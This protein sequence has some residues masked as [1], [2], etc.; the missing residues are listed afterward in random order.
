M[1]KENESVEKLEAKKYFSQ[2]FLIDSFAKK[3]VVKAMKQIADI[4][5]CTL[6]EVGPGQGDV[7][8]EV[9]L[10]E[11]S[12]VSI[13]ID[14]DAINFL[15]NN[16]DTSQF[17]LIHADI[18][19]VFGDELHLLLPEE[20][21]QKKITKKFENQ[22]YTLPK[23]FNLISSLPYHIGS[24]LLVDL[25]I[26]RPEVNFGVI[27]QREV[28]QKTQF[29]SDITFFG[30]WLNLFWD[31][32]YLFDIPKHCFRPQP[33]VVSSFLQGY[34]YQIQEL[35]WLNSPSKR[36][37]AKQILKKLFSFPN[38]TLLNNLKSLDWTTQKSLEFIEFA[39][40]DVKTR[41]NWQN[42]KEILKKVI[43]F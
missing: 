40:I 25:A 1:I 14:F 2:N 23:H 30:A 4:N 21:K 3:R 12:F 35:E 32:K 36:E 17:E 39:N 5:D 22:K 31:C 43:E 28:I 27:H 38:K 13:E 7:T 42:Y 18:M 24:R 11:K 9:L 15:K 8:S 37:K 41:L 29:N 20:F 34:S 16:L 10:W 19:E 6:L 26:I 33:K